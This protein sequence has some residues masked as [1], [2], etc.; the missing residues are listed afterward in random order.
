MEPS[1]RAAAGL[2]LVGVGALALTALFASLFPDPLGTPGMALLGVGALAAAAGAAQFRKDRGLDAFAGGLVVAALGSV[3]LAVWSLEGPGLYKAGFLLLAA[4]LLQA[5]WVGVLWALDEEQR[6]P[7]RSAAFRIAMA[8][9]AAAAL[10]FLVLNLAGGLVFLPSSVL[11]LAGFAL[12]GREL[13]GVDPAHR[14]ARRAAR[15]AEG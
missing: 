11:F 3:L 8:P 4:G 1:Q 5:A 10:W 15:A 7:R 14:G 6:G 2:A 9:C 12:A 13:R